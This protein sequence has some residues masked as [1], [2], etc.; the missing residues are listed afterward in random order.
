MCIVNRLAYTDLST[1]RGTL[2]FI[3]NNGAS[4]DAQ[5]VA[6]HVAVCE[7]SFPIIIGTQIR[8][9][10]F[11]RDPVDSLQEN[12]FAVDFAYPGSAFSGA[13]LH[14]RH[15]IDL[16]PTCQLRISQVSTSSQV[17]SYNF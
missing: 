8:K 17:T 2:Q 1:V 5:N 12:R 6:S 13:S 9:V 15:S 7:K 4:P 10:G 16:K 3:F 14:L 11:Y